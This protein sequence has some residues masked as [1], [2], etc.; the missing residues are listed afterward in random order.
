[1]KSIKILGL[2]LVAAFAMSALAAASASASVAPEF[3]SCNKVAK[4][5]MSYEAYKPAKGTKPAA[6][7]PKAKEVYEGKYATKECVEEAATPGKYADKTP[8]EV[9]AESKPETDAIQKSTYEGAEGKYELEAVVPGTKYTGK[10][11]VVK[12]AAHGVKGEA[13]PQ[14][15]ECTKGKIEG[16][17]VAEEEPYPVVLKSTLKLEKCTSNGN[18][19][20]KCGNVAEETIA[21]ETVRLPALGQRR[22]K[23]ARALEIFPVSSEQLRMRRRRSQSSRLPGRLDRKHRERHEGHLRG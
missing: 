19:Q 17:F 23:R 5:A 6:W 20:D 11:G 16:E 8:A 12:L 15:V 7:T 2:C 13:A 21:E 3:W 18:K 10:V 9:V 22:R 14:D 1:M 4:K